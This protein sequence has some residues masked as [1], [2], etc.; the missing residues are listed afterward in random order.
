MT[1]FEDFIDK[2][3]DFPDP[4]E[5]CGL[6]PVEDLCK[7]PPTF[8][9][10]V[11]SP[12]VPKLKLVRS[13]DGYR[14]QT[15]ADD[16]KSKQID[17]DATL[18]KTKH[19]RDWHGRRTYSCAYRNCDFTKA[20]RAAVIGHYNRIHLHMDPFMCSCDFQTWNSD[21]WQQHQGKG[22]KKDFFT[23]NYCPFACSLKSNL[24]SHVKRIHT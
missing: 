14:V 7:A 9:Y 24:N 4:E 6:T 21:A 10:K 5:L 19:H 22:C 11:L 15:D 2:L 12:K 3:A 8:L 17:E 13:A 16:A 20:T 1:S 18:P 23:C